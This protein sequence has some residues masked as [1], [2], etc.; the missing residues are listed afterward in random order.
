MASLP[1]LLGGEY[2][3]NRILLYVWG[4]GGI[5]TLPA[6]WAGNGRS[7]STTCPTVNAMAQAPA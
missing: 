1:V 7:N 2:Y 6:L 3:R 5:T 4:P